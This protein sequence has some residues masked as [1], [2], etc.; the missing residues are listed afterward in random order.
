VESLKGIKQKSDM[1][2]FAFLKDYCHHSADNAVRE[3]SGFS[4]YAGYCIHSIFI[5]GNVFSTSIVCQFH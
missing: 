5:L 3:V 2:G 4:V 1:T